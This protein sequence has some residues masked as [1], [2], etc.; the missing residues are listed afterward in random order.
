MPVKPLPLPEP[1]PAFKPTLKHQHTKPE[2]FS[3]DGKYKDPLEVK[4]ELAEYEAERLKKVKPS[5]IN[6]YTIYVYAIFVSSY[7]SSKQN[8]CRLLNRSSLF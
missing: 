4:A 1:L 7:V 5:K 6:I 2:P 8:H 3:F